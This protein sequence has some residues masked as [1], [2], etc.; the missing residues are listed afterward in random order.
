MHRTVF[1]GARIA[2]ERLNRLTFP[3]TRLAG[4]YY[5]LL[6]FNYLNEIPRWLA[7]VVLYDSPRTPRH[8]ARRIEP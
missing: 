1:G 3:E 5:K 2:P 4:F 7:L 6:N 8:Y